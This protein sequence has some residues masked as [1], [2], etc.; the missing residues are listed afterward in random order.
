MIKIENLKK[1]YNGA[2][3]LDIDE[4]NIKEGNSF[5]LVGNNGAGKTTLFRLILDL[6]KADTGCV[7]SKG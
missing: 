7:E 5:G 3:V 2:L 1:S 4:L 6:I